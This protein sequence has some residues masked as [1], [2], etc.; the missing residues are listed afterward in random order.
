[1]ND[2]AYDIAVDDFLTGNIENLPD[3]FLF[4]SIAKRWIDSLEDLPVLSIKDRRDRYKHKASALQEFA[5][6]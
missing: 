5:L 6:F 3:S 1:M 4:E 2:D